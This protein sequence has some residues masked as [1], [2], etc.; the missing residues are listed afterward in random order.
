MCHTVLAVLNS[1]EL[2]HF[3]CRWQQSGSRCYAQIVLLADYIDMSTRVRHDTD[4][5]VRDLYFEQRFVAQY[6]IVG[7]G[8]DMKRVLFFIS[9]RFLRLRLCAFGSDCSGSLLRT[10]IA[11]LLSRFFIGECSASAHFCKVVELVTGQT[12]SFRWTLSFVRVRSTTQTTLGATFS[13]RYRFWVILIGNF[14][15]K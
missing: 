8:T 1:F 6:R 5:R 15:S 12:S 3:C 2:T 9:A 7:D 4:W 14:G 10:S 13:F 11:F